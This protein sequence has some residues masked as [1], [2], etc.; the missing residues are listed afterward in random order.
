ME[1]KYLKCEICGAIV[2]GFGIDNAQKN[3]EQHKLE[4]HNVEK[5]VLKIEADIEVAE[6]SDEVLEKAPLEDYTKKEL[7]KA[8]NGDDIN[9]RMTKIQ[10][11]KAIEA[12]EE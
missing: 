8:F 10:I 7:L 2:A 9:S 11:I 3:L 6:E 12:R 5:V 4:Q 1:T